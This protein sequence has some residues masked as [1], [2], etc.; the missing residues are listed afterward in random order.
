MFY[1]K[2]IKEK[3]RCT[4]KKDLRINEYKNYIKVLS[5]ENVQCSYNIGQ[6]RLIYLLVDK[7]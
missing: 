6:Y 3:Q 2:I 5:S 7:R 1:I 4:I